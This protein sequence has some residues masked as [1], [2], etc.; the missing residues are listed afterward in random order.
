MKIPGDL[1]KW[2]FTFA[3]L[4]AILWWSRFLVLTVKETINNP[5]PGDVVAVAGVGVLLGAM[6][7]WAGQTVS[8]WFRKSPPK[9]GTSAGG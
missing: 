3:L 2:L 6:I 4:G 7:T 5:S 9:D 1:P 8:Y